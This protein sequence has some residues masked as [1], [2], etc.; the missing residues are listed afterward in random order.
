MPDWNDIRYVL[1]VLRTGSTL[2][3]SRRLKVSQ[4]TVMRRIAALEEALAIDLFDKRRT[5][6]VAT[7]ALCAL[8]PRIEQIEATR[9]RLRGCR[10]RHRARRLRNH[11]ADGARDRLL[12]SFSMR[13]SREY[14]A[15][16]PRSVSRSLRPRRSSILG[17]G[18]RIL[19]SGLA[20][21]RPMAP[22]S[23]VVYCGKR[24][25]STAARIMARGTAYPAGSRTFLST[26]YWGYRKETS[27]ARSPNGFNE[28][29]RRI[30][31]SCA[32]AGFRLSTSA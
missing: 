1:E 16:I 12:P 14:D 26:R 4:S 23:D 5:G 6:Y 13:R 21:G 8:L 24:G 10:F 19:R 7:E 2:A 27:P 3:A 28:I 22:C 20:P 25:D 18:K 9:S 29:C 11:H 15:S 30:A 17:M 32:I 31:S